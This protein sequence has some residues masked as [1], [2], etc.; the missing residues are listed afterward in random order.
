MDFCKAFDS[1]PHYWLLTKMEAMGITGKTLA[2][3][4][5]F[6]S[7]WNMRT[8]V[9]GFLS[10]LRKVVSRVPQGSVLGPLLFVIFINDLPGDLSNKCKLFADDLKLIGSR[11]Q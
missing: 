1:V 11:C 10:N 4:N 7:D 8:S 9:G 2:I 5:N 6:L 3:I